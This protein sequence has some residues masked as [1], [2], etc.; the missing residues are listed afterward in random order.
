MVIDY[1]E[2][3]LLFRHIC[4]ITWWETRNLRHFIYEH[5]QKTD[6][7]QGVEDKWT[8]IQS[9]IFIFQSSEYFF[10]LQIKPLSKINKDIEVSQDAHSLEDKHI[11]IDPKKTKNIGKSLS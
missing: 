6:T 1:T 3:A 11:E 8:Y 4:I 10:K 2:N 9:D 5:F 7:F